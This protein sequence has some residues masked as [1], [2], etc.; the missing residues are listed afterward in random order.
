MTIWPIA[1]QGNP[2]NIDIV[3]LSKFYDY[4]LIFRSKKNGAKSPV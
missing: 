1:Y 2:L 3:K 4:N